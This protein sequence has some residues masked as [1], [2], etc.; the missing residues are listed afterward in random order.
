MPVSR[1]V[2]SKNSMTLK[3]GLWVVQGHW[4]RSIDHI[5]PPIGRPLLVAYSCVCSIFE[6]DVE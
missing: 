5:R 1:T 6:F 3:Y 4:R 2:S